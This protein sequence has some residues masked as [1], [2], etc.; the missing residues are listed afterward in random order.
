MAVCPTTDIPKSETHA[1]LK[2]PQNCGR[3]AF[4]GAPLYLPAINECVLQSV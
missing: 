4:A 1:G 3:G 2:R